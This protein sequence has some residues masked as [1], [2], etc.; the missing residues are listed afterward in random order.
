MIRLVVRR[1]ATVLG[2]EVEPGD[3]LSVDLASRE[4][5]VL[6]ARIPRNDGALLV[7]LN[8][9]LVDPVD[10]TP[11][12]ARELLEAAQPPRLPLRAP[13]VLHLPVRRASGDLSR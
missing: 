10:I 12:D 13:R 2:R 4:C 11:D 1:R 5:V 7:A 6:A 3:V 8:D 9:G